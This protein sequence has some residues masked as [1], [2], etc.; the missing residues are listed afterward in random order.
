[1]TVY[2]D[3]IHTECP[4]VEFVP[5]LE[6]FSNNRFSS[7]SSSSSFSCPLGWS[8]LVLLGPPWSVVVRLCY[9][10]TDIDVSRDDLQAALKEGV[11]TSFN[12]ISIDKDQSTSDTCVIMSSNKVSLSSRYIT[13]SVRVARSA[14]ENTPTDKMKYS[15]RDP[16]P[17]H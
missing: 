1:M 13:F 11:E 14:G 7:S 2:S 9:V 10:M 5:K 16:K 3:S 4:Y 17:S 12:C 8:S 6:H 15:H